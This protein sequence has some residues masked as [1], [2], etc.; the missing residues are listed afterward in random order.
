MCNPDDTLLHTTGHQDAGH[1]QILFCKDWDALSQWAARRTSCYHD[2]EPTSDEPA[3]GKC[4]DGD[5]LPV[6]SLLG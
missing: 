6:G 5:G 3:F 4:K 1:G 2:R